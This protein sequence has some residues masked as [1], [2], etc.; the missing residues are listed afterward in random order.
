[1]FIP[2]YAVA[3]FGL[4]LLVMGFTWGYGLHVWREGQ[5]IQ[6]KVRSQ[7]QRERA[8]SKRSD[9]AFN[10]AG[11]I[12][13]ALKAETFPGAWVH[14]YPEVRSAQ[15]DH[16]ISIRRGRQGERIVQVVV[17]PADSLSGR[18]IRVWTQEAGAISFFGVDEASVSKAIDFIKTKLPSLLAS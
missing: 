3:V 14:L 4:A 18:E 10:I 12:A 6:A 2:Y 9:T 1:V 17:A 11:R 7:E 5:R 13:N 8:E 15:T 16:M